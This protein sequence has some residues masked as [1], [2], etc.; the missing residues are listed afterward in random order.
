MRVLEGGGETTA[1]GQRSYKSYASNPYQVLSVFAFCM[2]VCLAA[3]VMFSARSKCS[4]W[5]QPALCF[6]HVSP[7]AQHSKGGLFTRKFRR[8]V[9]Y[10][11]LPPHL[12]RSACGTPC[13]RALL[14][15]L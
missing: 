14:V 1:A 9:H 12:L 8:P 10:T 13:P 4:F 2:L 3:R 6:Q 11:H 7:R 15:L 5:I